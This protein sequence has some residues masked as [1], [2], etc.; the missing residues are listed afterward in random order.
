MAGAVLIHRG[1][2][3]VGNDE[4]RMT[5]DEKT[6]CVRAEGKGLPSSFVIRHSSFSEP[7]HHV[8]GELPDTDTLGFRWGAVHNL[9]LPA[10]DIAGEEWKAARTRDTAPDPEDAE[11]ALCQFRH[12]LPYIG[13]DDLTRLDAG[14]VK[15]RTT[16][17][18]RG[19]V[20]AHAEQL[21]LGVDCGKWNV[22]YVAVSWTPTESGLAQIIDYG[23]LDVHSDHQATERALLTTLRQIRDL[24]IAGWSQRGSSETRVPDL[25]LVD[26]GFWSDVVYGFCREPDSDGFAPCKG[27]GTGQQRGLSRGVDSQYTRPNRKTQTVRRIGREYHVARIKK[28]RVQLVELNADHWKAFVQDALRVAAD[29][30][31]AMT[32]FN[33]PAREHEK[34][35][36]HVAAERQVSEFVPKKGTVVK[37]Q[38]IGTRQNHYL[39]CLAYA[40]VA[41]HLCGAR[42]TDETPPPEPDLPEPGVRQRFVMP[43]ES[44]L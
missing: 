29:S 7:S 13:A 34:I 31:G 24:C 20:P 25:V 1:Q 15:R 14:Q 26:S 42:L 22:H 9:F 6:A 11:K 3:I 19:V 18:P 21:T 5:N 12:A 28:E 2:R 44:R 8:V 16:S 30:P 17:L 38:R 4:F 37:V 43:G 35:A 41:G 39:D 36:H 33:A 23:I 10:A 27:Y 40:S 32:L